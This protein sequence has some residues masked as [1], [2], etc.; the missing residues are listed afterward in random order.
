MC[1]SCQGVGYRLCLVF[2]GVAAGDA[3]AVAADAAAAVE[4]GRTPTAQGTPTS[5]ALFTSGV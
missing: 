2:S 1:L 4:H 5:F 3:A